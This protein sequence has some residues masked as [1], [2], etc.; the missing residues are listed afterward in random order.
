MATSNGAS[1][2]PALRQTVLLTDRAWPDDHI[3]RTVIEA[4]GLELLSG[5]AAPSEPE[6]IE[7]L[8][9]EHRPS[10][11]LTCWAPVSAMAISRGAA[12]GLRHV[13]RM[14]VGL[15]NIA[16]DAATEGGVLVTNVPD[17]C[18]AEVSDH[19][20][21]MVLAWARGLVASD[22]EVRAGRWNP[23]GAKLRRLSAL[24][25]GI[26]GLGRI[27]RTTAAKLGALGATV[28]ASDPYAGSGE[29][30]ALV[31][32]DEL[33]ATSDAIVLHAPLTPGT[34][35]LIGSDQLAAMKPDALLVNVS[36]GGL[37]DTSA[38]VDSLHRGH[39]GAAA[40]DVLESEPDVPE[41]LL[42]HPAVILTPHTAFSSDASLVDLRRGAAEEVVRVLRGEQ[43]RFPC[44]TPIPNGR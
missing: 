7:K 44:N 4:A 27:G 17:Y 22:R 41:E 1:E 10:A 29:K 8:V 6:V 15:D 35:H 18:V 20:V 30:V 5:P 21:G 39:L 34:R 28:I 42:R 2:P 33:L 13:A 3:E 38:L 23:A 24:T 14:G 26:V 25:I 11:V 31:G 40:L 37:V 43:P 36:R 19:A 9:E 16:V 12:H 32:F